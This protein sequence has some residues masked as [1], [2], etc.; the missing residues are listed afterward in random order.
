M[1]VPEAQ[2]VLDKIIAQVFG[3]K[4]PLTLEQFQQKFCFDINLP[5]EVYDSVDGSVTWAQSTNPTKYV[6][7]ENARGL[8]I[9]GA[10]AENDWLRPKRNLTNIEDILS[11]WSEINYTTTDRVNDSLNVSKSDNVGGSENVYHSTD[12]RKSRNVIFCDGVGNSEF[13]AACQR[14]GDLSFCMRVDDSGDI[15]NSFGISWCGNITNCMFMHDA[16]DMQDSLFCTNIKGKRFCVA[17]MQYSEEEYKKIRDIVA[18]WV[19]TS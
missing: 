7:L 13:V 1:T 14:S 17:N 6:K 5:Q 19:L 4:N 8:E 11:A 16:G 15:T 2:L 9:G 18:R 10:S 12:V 3:Y